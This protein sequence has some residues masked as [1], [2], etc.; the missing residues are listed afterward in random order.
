M[1][2][3]NLEALKRKK[4]YILKWLDRFKKAKGLLPILNKSLDLTS[5]EIEVL[6]NKPKDMDLDESS[7]KDYYDIDS[8]YLA[9]TLPM[10]PEIDS[11]N[12]FNLMVASTSGSSE[13]F[14][15]ILNAR[16][17]K[18]NFKDS[19]DYLVGS[20]HELQSKQSRAQD[21]RN[22][23]MSIGNDDLF[24]R[25]ERAYNE[26]SELSVKVG[27]R[28]ST[29]SEIRNLLYGI[30]GELFSLARDTKKENMNWVEM[31]NRLHK[32]VNK[33]VEHTEILK[34]ELHFS[35]LIDDLSK[36][37]KSREGENKIS[38]EDLWVRVLDLLFIILTSIKINA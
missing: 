18:D 25:F 1:K 17:D 9:K 36:V 28:T 4:E 16:R 6:E 14:S 26:Y 21:V 29:A 8:E 11:D 35:S 3:R 15:F 34:Q 5:W 27:V 24:K 19:G 37:L 7:E 10:I 20:Y 23:I 13:T 12:V 2:T 30:K 31:A 38:I 32:G 33:G 22:L